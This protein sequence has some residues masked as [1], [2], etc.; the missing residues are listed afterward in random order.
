MEAER[1]M[2]K[3]KGGRPKKPVKKEAS[4]S[5]HCSPFE[6]QSIESRARQVHLDA[7]SYLRELGLT[8]KIGSR[9]KQLPKEVL[10]LKALLNHLAAN[11]NQVAK[12]RNSNEV[13]GALE[14]ADLFGLANKIKELVSQIKSYL[15]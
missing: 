7:S 11:M 13:L 3:N 8:G 15:Q 6:K 10:E 2:K 5:V 1:M 9:H 14:R 12:K 4:I